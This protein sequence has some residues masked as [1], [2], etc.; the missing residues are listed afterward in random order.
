MLETKYG[1]QPPTEEKQATVEIEHSILESYVGKYIVFSDVMEVDLD[2]D[3]L[4][5][6]VYG[7]SFNLDPLSE[8][9][10]QPRNWL[11]DIGLASLLGAPVD[12]RQLKIEF[13]PGD[14]ISVDYVIIHLGGINYE[15]C[16]E[17]PD[18]AEVPPLWEELTGEYILLA[19][20]P[21]G[22]IGTDVLGQTKIRV[23]DGALRMASLVR[24]ILPISETELIILSGPFAGET[25]MYDPETGNIYH[26][27]IVYQMR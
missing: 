23:E 12:L 26:Q 10:F 19:R 3:L 1:L 9:L 25:I 6:S 5:G 13:M 11:A 17:Y 14:E 2:G 15:I 8:T 7:F 4:K 22:K 24:P 18:L 21:S 16:P 20:S 27:N